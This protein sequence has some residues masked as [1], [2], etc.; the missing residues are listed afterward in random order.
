MFCVLNDLCLFL[1]L[2]EKTQSGSQ[3]AKKSEKKSELEEIYL[4]SNLKQKTQ[5]QETGQKTEKQ[6]RP[7]FGQQNRILKKK[8]SG[9]GQD[10]RS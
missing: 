7:A 9:H 6:N 1:Q 3:K 5:R 10:G 2:D 4:G 8:K